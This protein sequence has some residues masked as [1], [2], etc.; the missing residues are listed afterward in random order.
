MRWFR[1]AEHAECKEGP[2]LRENTRTTRASS[3]INF[4]FWNMPY[5]AEHHICP[6]VP[7]H[8]LPRLHQVVRDKLF[9]VGEGY[10]KVHAD[11]LSQIVR[12]Q[13]VTWKTHTTDSL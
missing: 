12:R 1:I 2:D 11:V 5:H 8:A 9:P 13:G 10:F 3:W 7:F 4:L 6:M